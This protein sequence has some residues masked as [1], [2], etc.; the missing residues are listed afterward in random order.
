MVIVLFPLLPCATMTG[1]GAAVSVKL[2]GTCTV[3]WIVVVWVKVPEMPV[4]VTVA[5]PVAAVA[6][7]VK[8][9]VLLLVAGLG[10]NF[11]VTPLGSPEAESVTL[12]LK[13]FNGVTVIALVPW[14]PWMTVRLLGLADSE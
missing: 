7:A 13:P 8:V 5:G 9:S 11:A 2:G 4:T 10:L 12:A 14:L 3:S 1:L 6:L